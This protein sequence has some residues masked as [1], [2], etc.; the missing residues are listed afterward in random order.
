M[1][2]KMLTEETVREWLEA[3]MIESPAAK[4][5]RTRIDLTELPHLELFLSQLALLKTLLILSDGRHIL[6]LGTFVGYSTQALVEILDSLGGGTITTVDSN[7]E[8]IARARESVRSSGA[9]DVTYIVDSAESACE[10]LA[11]RG[12]DFDLILLDVAESAYLRLYE[13]CIRLLRP[14][15]I[16]VIDNVLMETVA[17]WSNGRNAVEDSQDETNLAL[18]ELNRLLLADTRVAT[19]VLPLGS[20][21]ALCTRLR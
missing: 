7:A 16:L 12:S 19:S 15:G 5:I 21:I 13:G 3:L 8:Y 4:A 1:E 9:T 2:L 11:D 20:G 17:G 6:E 14:G 18:A 10:T